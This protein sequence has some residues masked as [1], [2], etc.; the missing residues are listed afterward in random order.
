MKLCIGCAVAVSLITLTGCAEPSLRSAIYK[1]FGPDYV[2]LNPSLPVPPKNFPS[3]AFR[4]MPGFITTPRYSALRDDLR[5]EAG[6]WLANRA[7]EECAP[8]TKA[9]M[10]KDV[11][12]FPRLPARVEYVLDSRNLFVP[13][14]RNDRQA[15]KTE[16][17]LNDND[18]RYVRRVLIHIYAV[19]DGRVT[20]AMLES[21]RLDISARCRGLFRNVRGVQ[22][23][24][25]TLSGVVIVELDMLAGAGAKISEKL[26]AKIER[27]ISIKSQ[28]QNVFFAVRTRSLR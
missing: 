2:V 8:T 25:S 4:Y 22:Q 15:V 10:F 14:T 19:Q 17:R 26:R 13:I 20:P 27:S 6:V 5:Q 9:Y 11:F 18:L 21:A 3:N 23:I 28:N 12:W 16:L 1:N 24:D 7:V